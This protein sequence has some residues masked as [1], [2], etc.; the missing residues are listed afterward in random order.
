MPKRFSTFRIR[1]NA[2]YTTAEAARAIGAK[3]QTIQLWI[4]RDGLRVVD[5]SIPRLILGQDLIDFVNARNSAKNPK[6]GPL[7]FLCFRCRQPRFPAFEAVEIIR[8]ARSGGGQVTAL[9]PV[10]GK[11]M[12]RFVD[13]ETLAEFGRAYEV[14]NKADL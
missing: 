8:R 7:Q 9:C 10:C 13:R 1:K 4:W 12:F 6:V 3:E 11:E 5:D 14:T 2:L